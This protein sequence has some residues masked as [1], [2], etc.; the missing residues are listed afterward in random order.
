MFRKLQNFLFGTL[1]NPPDAT[2]FYNG[3]GGFSTPTGA[4][5]TPRRTITWVIDGGGVAIATG[6]RD[7]VTVPFT[8][9][10]KKWRILS[11]DDSI[12]SGSIVI[13]LWKD[14]YANFPPTVA[15]TIAAAAKPTVVTDIKAEDATLTGWTIA[16][17][18]GDIIRAN[19]DSASG[20]IKVRLEVE[21]E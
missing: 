2:V 17:T 1:P 20:F 16:I 10:I 14:T 8:C 19:V 18:A 21:V 13:D 9:T 15:D 5:G 3:A 7:V 4:G 11:S 12:T 6:A